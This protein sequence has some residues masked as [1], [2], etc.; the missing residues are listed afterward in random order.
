[1][2]IINRR[3][4]KPE[5]SERNRFPTD[6]KNVLDQTYAKMSS[7]FGDNRSEKKE[8]V[9]HFAPREFFC[10]Y[11]L[12]TERNIVMTDPVHFLDSNTRLPSCKHFFEKRAIKEYFL[13]EDGL[14]T[15]EDK[16]RL[17]LKS[18]ARHVVNYVGNTLTLGIF[19]KI[20]KKPERNPINKEIEFNYHDKDIHRP[21]VCPVDGCS[22]H[23]EWK[24]LREAM[25]CRQVVTLKML[26]DRLL[27]KDYS[28]YSKGELLSIQTQR[29]VFDFFY[30]IEKLSAKNDSLE[31][32]VAKLEKRVAK[33]E[34]ENEELKERAAKLEKRVEELEINSGK[35]K[36]VFLKVL[37]YITP[38]SVPQWLHSLIAEVCQIFSI[39]IPSGFAGAVASTGSCAVF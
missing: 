11:S 8:F 18:A 38:S 13:G 37:G 24:N 9:R 16:C 6:D 12:E 3:Y 22:K 15:R 14:V 5:D 2:T 25:L 33:L 29:V 23:I 36:D 31:K 21:R 1:M 26:D 20:W 4:T 39:A 27:N 35:I 7:I 10:D 19:P 32:R 30:T 28:V 34:K 17:A